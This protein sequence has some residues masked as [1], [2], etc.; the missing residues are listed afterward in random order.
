ME[1]CCSGCMPCL[2]LIEPCCSG[3]MPCL[4]GVLL[5]ELFAD[6]FC[7][8]ELE[9][10]DEAS[11]SN[12]GVMSW[13]LDALDSPAVAADGPGSFAVGECGVGRGDRELKS[14]AS[15]AERWDGPLASSLKPFKSSL[16]LKAWSL[17]LEGHPAPD[18]AS[19]VLEGIAG[20]V[21]LGF[22]GPR[23]SPLA[24]NRPSAGQHAAAIA[25]NIRKEVQAGRVAGPF[26]VSPF[27]EFRTSPLG[28]VPK[29]DSVKMRRIHDLS[30]PHGASVNA[31][32]EDGS[33]SYS[34]FDDAVDMIRSLGRGCW[35]WKSDLADA[36]RHISVHPEDIAL[37]GFVWAGFLFFD[38]ALPFGLRSSPKI[39]EIFATALQWIV[40][41]KLGF[42]FI[43]HYLDDFLGAAPPDGH[44]LAAAQFSA[45]LRAC[46]LLGLAVNVDK[47]FAPRKLLAFLGVEIDTDKM[48]IQLPPDKMSKL[49]QRIQQFKGLRRCR[50]K[51]LQSLVGSLSYAC[52]AV[53]PGRAFL[54]RMLDALRAAKSSGGNPW[55]TLDRNFHADLAWWTLFLDKW[56]GVH[57]IVDTN[58]SDALHV[59]TDA[60]DVGA[61]AFHRN[62]WWAVEWTAE[63]KP[64][65]IDWRELKAVLLAAAAWAPLWKGRH[66]V[67]HVD[68]TVAVA[69]IRNMTSGS[70]E[71]A[72]LARGLHFLAA[73]FQFEF[74]SIY[75]A[76]V[77]NAVA[78]SLSRQQLDRFR[79]LCPMAAA[80]PDRPQLSLMISC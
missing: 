71:L 80:S 33:V 32:I 18:V 77:R 4:I 34:R 73:V 40:Q 25:D 65:S 8:P 61:G 63:E 28:A 74:S 43:V 42:R 2:A 47:C 37:L 29:K 54:R 60:S 12:S 44:R 21:K 46:G 68:N 9:E 20:G 41:S 56:N 16:N 53:R 35:L 14:S 11:A 15:A 66:V 70:A 19:F 55:V 52:K 45:F 30:H 24:S 22:D 5:S 36:F 58:P 69:V 76:G 38:L 1:P 7:S 31:F 10:G 59:S 67:F 75:I 79:S 62:H 23:S 48:V 39:F 64:K 49:R 51:Q 3:C 57:S 17:M 27:A 13:S 72:S 26:A 50:L 6:A 78:D